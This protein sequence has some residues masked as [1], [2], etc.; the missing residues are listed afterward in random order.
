MQIFNLH[1][2]YLCRARLQPSVLPLWPEEQEQAVVAMAL[3]SI[4]RIRSQIQEEPESLVRRPSNALFEDYIAVFPPGYQRQVR[5]E[6]YL[7]QYA[8]RAARIHRTG[9]AFYT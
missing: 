8:L 6:A 2:G 5:Q 4:P 1:I 7:H 9:S 3:A